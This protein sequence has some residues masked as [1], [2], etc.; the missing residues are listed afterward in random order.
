[1]RVT[2]A[3]LLGPGIEAAPDRTIR[4]GYPELIEA[5]R[6]S[7]TAGR[8]SGARQRRSVWIRQGRRRSTNG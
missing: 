7:P 3:D 1:M 8:Y 5:E 6:L 2:G 4:T